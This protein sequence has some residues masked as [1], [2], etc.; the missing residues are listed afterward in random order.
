MN[1]DALLPLFVATRPPDS[2][3]IQYGLMYAGYTLLQ[4]VQTE[5]YP[6]LKTQVRNYFQRR[7]TQVLKSYTSPT[8]S[9]IIFERNFEETGN[10]NNDL[11]DAVLDHLCHLASVTSLEY[12]RLYLLRGLDAFDVTDKIKGQLLFVNKQDHQPTY[13][14][15]RIYSKEYTIIELKEWAMTISNRYRAKKNNALNGKQHYFDSIEENDHDIVFTHTPFSTTKTL[16]NLYGEQVQQIRARVRKFLYQRDWY[17]T[18][19]IPYTLGFLFSGDPGTGKTSS[20]K[21]IARESHR[22]VFNVHLSKET[23]TNAFRKLFLTPSVCV[24]SNNGQFQHIEIPI[25]ERIYVF[26]DV[27]CLTDVFLDRAQVEMKEERESRFLTPEERRNKQIYDDRVKK[28]MLNLSTVLNILDGILETPGRIIIFTSNYPEKIDRAVLR[29]GRVD[30]CVSF[31]KCTLDTLTEMC[32]AY[33]DVVKRADL[34]PFD[35]L[36]S[37]ASV[38]EMILKSSSFTDF[39]QLARSESF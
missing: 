7:K 30:S 15:F 29:P 31:T 25:D 6:I 12:I 14:R 17:E 2:N 11:P 9:E 5:L 1:F 10:S 26:E 3:L 39:L 23:T 33:F 18:R 32:S 35:G 19:G 8:E 21:A 22:H 36:L 4:F 20:I 13:I 24:K 34:E 16:D 37:P 28:R 27:D 38:Q